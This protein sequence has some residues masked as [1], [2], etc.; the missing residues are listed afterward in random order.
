MKNDDDLSD[1]PERSNSEP[2]SRGCFAF[3]GSED[4]S[5]EINGELMRKSR[6][7]DEKQTEGKL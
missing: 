4:D 6:P 1:S 3:E 5:I 2:S 7:S